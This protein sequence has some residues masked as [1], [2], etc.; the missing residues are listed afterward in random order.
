MKRKKMELS[1]QMKRKN[2]RI[3]ADTV[4]PLGFFGTAMIE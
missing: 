2:V 1:L 4:A 3:C